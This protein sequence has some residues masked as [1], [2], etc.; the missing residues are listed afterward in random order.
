MSTRSKTHN[1]SF[2]QPTIFPPSMTPSKAD[3]F[4]HYLFVR[5]KEQMLSRGS[6]TAKDCYRI[7]ANDVKEIWNT[8]SFPCISFEAIALKVE[9]LIMSATNLNKVPIKQRNEKFFEKLEKFDEM[10]DICT[11]TCFDKKIKRTD[12]RCDIRISRIEWESFAG[13]KRRINQ[14][15]TIDRVTTA[16]RKRTHEKL[17]TL[18]Q[19][20]MKCSSVPSTSTT[21]YSNSD[22]SD[23]INDS[24][25]T[26]TR[27]DSS[28]SSFL[29]ECELRENTQNRFT[30]DKL[31]VTADRYRVSSR[32]AAAIVNAALEDMGILNEGNMLDRKKVERERKRIGV[33]K[34]S[35][36]KLQNQNIICIGFDGRKNLS[37][38]LRG[39]EHEEHVV[40]VKEPGDVYM[41]HISPDNGTARCIA[42][43]LITFLIDSHSRDT[44][45]AI[46]CDGT[47]VNTGRIGG[48]LKLIEIEI[49]RPLQWLICLL[50]ANELPFRHVFECIDGKTSGPT[51]F[52]GMIGKKISKDLTK[53]NIVE[54]TPV[55]CDIKMPEYIVKDLSTDQKYLYE[56]CIGITTGRIP[57]N[58]A[59][60]SPGALHHARWL[61]KANRILRL[62]VSTLNPEKNLQD[63]VKI[64]LQ[65]YAPGWFQIKSHPKATEG[66]MNLY[67]L[68]SLI[69]KQ[70]DEH[71]IIMENV[72]RNNAYFAHCENILIA[73]MT[74]PRVEIRKLAIDRIIKARA[75]KEIKR[76]F[77]LPMDINFKASDYTEMIDWNK[78]TITSPPLLQEFSNDDLIKAAIK[79]LEIPSVPCH[80]QGVERLISLVTRASEDRIGYGNRHK[81]VLNVIESRKSMPTFEHKHQWK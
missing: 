16:A 38:T 26:E 63:L 57:Q 35:S 10:F 54:F 76:A 79:P 42:D 75:R 17:L 40:I 67:Y 18:E 72:F 59:L 27:S 25:D 5:N 14:L 62:Y 65:V 69:G 51:S 21:T 7:V 8:F 31:S 53:A 20:A 66:A 41:D 50:H 36:H 33:K 49:E 30:Y 29:P 39:V 45:Q 22:S 47:V 28:E 3:V 46:L 58:L 1:A 78:T 61:T 12:C 44:L 77:D 48:I 81:Y 24:N 34:D 60:K 15:G 11:C 23:D 74:D 13:Q 2:G 73:M 43:E 80:T 4:R 32:A 55:Q 70:E 56:M 68:M 19:A 9:R 37:K 52:K 6:K 71:R 64:I